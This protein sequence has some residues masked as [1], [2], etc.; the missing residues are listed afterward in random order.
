VT[1]VINNLGA[2][3]EGFCPVEDAEPLLDWLIKHPGGAV[4]LKDC[5]NLHTSVLQV[6]MIGKAQLANPPAGL[7]LS[8][9]AN[10][11]LPAF[12]PKKRVRKSSVKLEK[13]QRK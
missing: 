8:E 13:A 2:S 10:V 6:L 7:E 9:W 5:E 1:I 12:E 11:V 4:D 3:L